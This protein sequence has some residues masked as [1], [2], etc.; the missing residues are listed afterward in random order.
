MFG[1]F[2]GA[3]QIPME[4][5]RVQKSVIG[6]VADLHTKAAALK[7]C[8]FLRTTTNRETRVPRTFRELVTH[9]REKELPNRNPYTQEVYKGYLKMWIIPK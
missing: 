2:A 6:T 4:A 5:S 1:H 8:E 3:K 7:A 9:Y